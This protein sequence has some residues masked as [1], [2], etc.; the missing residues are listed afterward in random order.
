VNFVL[1]LNLISLIK[2]VK[3]DKNYG[4]F[5]PWSGVATAIALASVI[6]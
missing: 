5:Y 3:T 1:E 6:A 2:I 4:P